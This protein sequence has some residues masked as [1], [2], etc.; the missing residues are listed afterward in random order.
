MP[1]SRVTKIAVLLG[2][3]VSGLA[4]AQ[5][6]SWAA[7]HKPVVAQ[8]DEK[9][10]YTG[11]L[12]LL[13]KFGQQQLSPYFVGLA[14]AYEAMHPG[15]HI[16]L[17]QQ[18][19]DSVKDK[20]KTLVA[21]NSLPD[22]YFSWTGNWG[23]NFV[24]GN[25]A[26]DLG[27]V[28]GPDTA[29]GKTLTPAAVA[30]FV[31]NDKNYGIPLYLDAKFMGYNKTVFTK[32]GISV[33]KSFDELLTA[34]D[35]IRKSGMVPISLGNKEAWPAI[36]YI[37]QLLA[38]TVP[39]AV[40]EKDF[41]PKTAHY[42][43]PGYVTALDDFKALE[44]RCTDGGGMN[45]VSYETAIQSFSNV[46]SAM[47]Y[48]EI[49]EFDGSANPQTPLKQAEFGFFVLPPP[50]DAKGTP[51]AI[52]GAPEGYMINTRSKHVGL[53]LDFMKFVTTKANGEVLSAPP[54]G[55]PSS[56]VGAVTPQNSSASVVAGMADL[57]ATPFL[58]PWLDTANTPRVAAA[59]LD[60]MQGLAGGTLTS[61]Q[62]VKNV[63]AAAKADADQ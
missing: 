60:G 8:P 52:E 5:P 62:V 37:G 16:T 42:T 55:Q 21:S 24:R 43:D 59:W 58:M 41:N 30:A 45:G 19:D 47:Y 25:R 39:Q 20:T 11:T 18:T 51:N 10:E 6:A 17:D 12:S 53:A 4:I 31:W 13:T 7:S 2:M 38:Y 9:V 54:Y 32:L 49:L 50:A 56:V 27:K 33:P 35:T 1:M 14:K 26:V 22:I 57:N 28:V 15:V 44:T 63:A 61:A 36:H 29:W 40:L 23:E 3:A 48:Q 46:K 34:C